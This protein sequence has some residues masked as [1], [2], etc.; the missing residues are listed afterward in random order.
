MA[1]VAVCTR[2]LSLWWLTPLWAQLTFNPYSGY[3]IGLPHRTSSGAGLGMGRLALIGFQTPLPDQPAHSAHL[4][5]MEADFSGWGRRAILTTPT[6]KAYF[7]TGGL[8][9]LQLSFARGKGWGFSVGL[10]PQALQGYQSSLSQ[11]TP[12]PFTFSEKAEGL[13]TQAY[14]QLAFRWKALALGYHFGYL[15]GSYDRQR[16]LLS[17]TQTYPDYLITQSRLYGIQ[18]RL[19]LLWQDTLGSTAWQL[20]VTYALPTALHREILYTLQKNF[21]LTN[22]LIDTFAHQQDKWAYS[23]MVGAGLMISFPRWSIGAEGRY[24]PAWAAWAGPG[25]PSA[26]AHPTWEVRMG[27]EWVPDPRSPAFYKRFR[28][29]AGG[30]IGTMPYANLTGYAL[31]AGIGW[32]FPRSPNV[33]FLSIEQGWLPHPQVAER[34][35]QVSVAVLFRELWFLPPRID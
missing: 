31:T 22:I 33:V 1:L 20:S 4:T 15:W 2:R 11:S 29:Q 35:T 34:Y 5:A 30:W 14:G 7:G 16:N 18:H 17:A 13:L 6:Q 27:G 21:S 8:Q 12:V 23:S 19:G 3:G 9:S 26:T 28:Y 32:Q 24:T 25:L 10:M